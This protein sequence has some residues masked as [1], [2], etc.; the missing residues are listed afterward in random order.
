MRG[1]LDKVKET[2]KIPPSDPRVKFRNACDKVLSIL[3]SG[4]VDERANLERALVSVADWLGQKPYQTNEFAEYFIENDIMEQICARISPDTKSEL[5]HPLLNFLVKFLGPTL[6][7]Y[8]TCVRVHD[9]FAGIIRRLELFDRKCPE[10]TRQFLRD[11]W[12]RV[13]ED[14]VRFQ[15]LA[16]H[17]DTGLGY[18]VLDYFVSACSLPSKSGSLVRSLI[19]KFFG[20]PDLRKDCGGYL[21]QKLWPI[22]K[23]LLITVSSYP[24]TIDFDGTMMQTL[25]WCG[26]VCNVSQF[27]VEEVYDAIK[28]NRPLHKRLASY[29]LFLVAFPDGSGRQRTVAYATQEPVLTDLETALAEENEVVMKC[30]LALLRQLAVCDEAR[31]MV[32]PP[33]SKDSVDILTVE[34]ELWGGSEDVPVVGVVKS[35]REDGVNRKVFGLVLRQLGRFEM[36]SLGMC[37]EITDFLLLLLAFAPDLMNKELVMSFE[38][39]VKN[40]VNVRP[41]ESMPCPIVDEKPVRAKI[42]AD[43]AKEIHATFVST[44]S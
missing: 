23:D 15:L 25:R 17:L 18:P 3:L 1:F 41:V 40:Y 32:L 21:E 26:E 33:K 2:L 13:E 16:V 43:F 6:S 37:V 8:L 5:I 44:T 20:N 12:D 30:G 34:P 14:P 36:L 22:L 27:K 19:L 29:A 24:E 4:A 28:T 42:L 38:K 11:L 9:A 35:E 39:A 7:E 31:K 10:E